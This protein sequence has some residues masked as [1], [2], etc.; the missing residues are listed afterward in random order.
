MRLSGGA[1]SSAPATTA[2]AANAASDPRAIAREARARH[3]AN[4][5]TTVTAAA[6]P[7]AQ[8]AAPLSAAALGKGPEEKQILGMAGRGRRLQAAAPT[9]PLPDERPPLPL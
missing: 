2:T 3:F 1:P 6:G 8:R 5:P 7:T 4:L 9:P